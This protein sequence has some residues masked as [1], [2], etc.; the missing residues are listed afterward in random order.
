MMILLLVFDREEDNILIN[1][2]PKPEVK[3]EE[4]TKQAVVK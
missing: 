3:K 4:I 2:S 1:I